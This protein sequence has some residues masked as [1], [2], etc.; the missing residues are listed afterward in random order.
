VYQGAVLIIDGVL[1][2]CWKEEWWTRELVA[3]L[4]ELMK[5]SF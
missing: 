4:D 3:M 2:E 1:R 5:G